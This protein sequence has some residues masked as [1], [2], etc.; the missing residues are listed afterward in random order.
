MLQRV[1]YMIHIPG[2]TNGGIKETFGGEIDALPTLLHILGIDTSKM[3]QLGQDLLSPQNS[4]IV[5]QRTSGT[6]ITPDYT[7]YSGR[8]YNT[9]TGLEITNPDE[10]TMAKV[11]EIR[12]AVAQQLAASDA[13]QTGDL[14]RFDTDNGLKPVDPTTLIYTKQLKQLKEISEKLGSHSTSIYSKNGNKSTQ[15]L[16]K[17]P[18]YLEL[19]PKEAEKPESSSSSDPK[20]E[21]VKDQSQ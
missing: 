13:I 7:S 6:Y 11:K 8:L 1:P 21:P 9:Q 4:Q 15:K 17:A 20:E 5:A 14:L 10:M 2:Y 12:A 19:N 3:V 18:S 16:F